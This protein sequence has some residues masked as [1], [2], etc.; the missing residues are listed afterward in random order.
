VRKVNWLRIIDYILLLILFVGWAY[1]TYTQ[2][3]SWSRAGSIVI[4]LIIIV[5]LFIEDRR[6]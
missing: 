6:K 4:P 3:F 5:L 1:L 2:G